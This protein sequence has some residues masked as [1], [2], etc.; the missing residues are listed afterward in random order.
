[1]KELIALKRSQTTNILAYFVF[2]L[3]TLIMIT[4]GIK[5]LLASSIIDGDGQEWYSLFKNG[6]IVIGN[7]LTV[8]IGY[9]FGFRTGDAALEKANEL[10][11]EA[12]QIQ[13]DVEILAPTTEADIGGIQNIDPDEIKEAE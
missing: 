11:S 4:V 12:E 5:V 6:F 7:L 9:Y 8:L 1:M 10:Y 3:F 13:K 2:G